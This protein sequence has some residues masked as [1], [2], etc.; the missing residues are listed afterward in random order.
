MLSTFLR[1]LF[2]R[3]H[4]SASAATTVDA[5]RLAVETPQAV[6]AAILELRAVADSGSAEQITAAINVFKANAAAGVLAPREIA[7]EV[8]KAEQM[9]TVLAFI[10]GL[11]RSEAVKALDTMSDGEPTYFRG[12]DCYR[13]TSRDDDCGQLDIG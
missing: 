3:E 7:D 10:D 5:P 9:L 6:V 1:A 4:H 8:T 12:I 11:N 2:G 13:E